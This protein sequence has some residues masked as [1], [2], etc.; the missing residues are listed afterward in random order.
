MHWSHNSHYIARL[1]H[2]V[3]H[4]FQIRILQNPVIKL[5]A[6]RHLNATKSYLHCSCFAWDAILCSNFFCFLLF[7]CLKLSFCLYKIKLFRLQT[8]TKF[9]IV[10]LYPYFPNQQSTQFCP[11][12]RY[13]FIAFIWRT[14]LSTFSIQTIYVYTG[15]QTYRPLFEASNLP[16]FE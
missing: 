6:T 15:L 5:K 12:C 3:T 4:R 9:S 1:Y 16:K 14:V 7:Y 13:D 8:W 11:K 2:F 10:C